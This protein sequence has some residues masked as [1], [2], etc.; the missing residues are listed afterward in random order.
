MFQLVSV[1]VVSLEIHSFHVNHIVTI[2]F[3]MY[4]LMC[5]DHHRAV[6]TVAAMK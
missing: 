6:C 2:Q 4:Q 1:K 3:Q 5:V